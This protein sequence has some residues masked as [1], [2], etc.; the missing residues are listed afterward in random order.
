MAKGPVPITPERARLYK[1]DITAFLEEQY[2]LPETG[3]LFVAEPWQEEL[4]LKPLFYDLLPDGRRRYTLA[5]LGMPKKH[6]KSTLLAGIAIWFCFA[7]EPHGEII[8]AANN[9][10]QAS[11][12]IYEKIRTAFKLNPNL[13][14][15]ARLLKGGIE[16]K[17]TGTI[18][19]P[20]A[21][22]Y[23]TAA[24]VNPTLTL[25]DELWGFEGREFYDELTTSPAR[26]NPL[27]VIGTY[28][29][30]DKDSLLYS[31]YEMGR[32]KEDPRMFFI[33]LQKNYASWVTQE[34]L[35]TQKR[36]LP[37]NSYA[38]FHENKW[39]AAEGTFVT[40]D[41]IARLHAIPWTI[42]YTPDASR[43]GLNYVLSCDAGLSHDRTA[44]C[45]GHYDPADGRVYV[46]NLRWWEGSRQK[47]VD[48]GEVE[49][50]L[51]DMGGRFHTQTMVI[52]PWQME[53]VMQR[54]KPRF[55]IQPFNFNIDM[56]FMSQTLVTMLRNGTLV[57]YAEPQLDKELREIVAKQTGQG[58]KI[59]HLK[60]K[61]H[62]LVIAVGMMAVTA[63]RNAGLTDI[64]FYTGNES[65]S[66]P[67]AF[68]GIREKEF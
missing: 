45:L 36:R 67:I 26:Q 50:D 2:I 55:A 20:I 22:K 16:M 31:L 54:L 3:K 46:D 24:G 37:P 17:S 61:R 65:T 7:G 41:D 68:R 38:R 58:W 40:E 29:G 49:N 33:W 18:C 1:T 30:Y 9:L 64:N 44:R 10:D 47:H 8:V 35:D 56:M 39:A 60:G 19:R 11:L 15:A 52:D 4:I 53:Y 57:C 28:A 43:P 62:D 14:A 23:Q 21:H 42:Q 32:K 48:L 59:E 51:G 5:L 25:F 12:I 13:A 63:V 27:T 6:G 66:R 34:Y